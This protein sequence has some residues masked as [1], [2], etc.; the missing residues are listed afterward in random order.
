MGICK[1]WSVLE[2]VKRSVHYSAITSLIDTK[3]GTSDQDVI[4]VIDAIPW[5]YHQNKNVPIH[6]T[7]FHRLARLYTL[8]VKAIFVF[9]GPD[10]PLIKRNRQCYSGLTA[11][12]SEIIFRRLLQLFGFKS[13]EAAGEAE[14]ECAKLLDLGIAD[15]V[16]TDDVDALMFGAQKMITN[17]QNDY[18]SFFDMKKINEQLELDQD[19]LVLIGLLAGNDYVP[20]GSRNIGILTAVGLAKAGLAPKVLYAKTAQEKEE[21]RNALISELKTNESGKL[22]RKRPSAA[23]VLLE[24]F[25]EQ[26]VVKLLRHPKCRARSLTSPEEVIQLKQFIEPDFTEL[27]AYVQ[28]FFH[29]PISE[30]R[31]K[32][33]SLLFPGYVLQCVKSEMRSSSQRKR[34]AIESI[35]NKQDSHS[36]K[37][38]LDITSYF[39]VNKKTSTQIGATKATKAP[40]SVSTNILCIN[41]ERQPTDAKTCHVKEYQVQINPACMLRFLKLI[42]KK[43]DYFPPRSPTLIFHDAY[44]SPYRNSPNDHQKSSSPNGWRTPV[45]NSGSISSSSSYAASD[46]EEQHAWKYRKIDRS[47]PSNTPRSK[48]IASSI[49]AGEENP[50]LKEVAN[51]SKVNRQWMDATM[52]L[53]AYPDIV[54]EYEDKKNAQASRKRLRQ[55]KMAKGKASSSKLERGQ[56]TI[57]EMAFGIQAPDGTIKITQD[58]SMPAS[59]VIKKDFENP[60]LVR[61]GSAIDGGSSDMRSLAS[62]VIPRRRKPHVG[63]SQRSSSHSG[64]SL[65]SHQYIEIDSDSDSEPI[66]SVIA[67]QNQSINKL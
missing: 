16:V 63:Q 34:N 9:D 54:C 38:K 11:S 27:A 33:V 29:L 49:R 7:L 46:D 57:T 55:S 1:L 15:L 20:Y 22:D 35:P 14:A 30:M 42:G 43:L 44:F 45:R 24:D 62:L 23:K 48:S 67:R 12:D 28:N 53:K 64:I 32:L 51:W 66:L 6:L 56:T 5:L 60:F 19:G 2:P 50:E 3:S 18:V 58:N 47:E 8:G 65:N 4:L 59:V 40:K 25:P 39:P 31:E 36:T 52:I 41:R 17:W 37:R 13:W 10:K 61:D 26:E 21:A